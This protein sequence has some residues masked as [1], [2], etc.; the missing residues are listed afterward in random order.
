MSPGLKSRTAREVL[1][2]MEQSF[3]WGRFSVH[4][5][6]HRALLALVD[7]GPNYQ[8]KTY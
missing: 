2:E 1:K 7:M 6:H 3:A 8:V 4:L 5:R